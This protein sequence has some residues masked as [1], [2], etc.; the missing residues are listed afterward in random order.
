MEVLF[1]RYQTDCQIIFCTVSPARNSADI[2]V[3]FI[4]NGVLLCYVLVGCVSLQT[5]RAVI[6]RAVMSSAHLNRALISSNITHCSLI[7]PAQ[8]NTS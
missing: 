3:N 7:P 5:H 4:C 8:L 6:F 1:G 2:C